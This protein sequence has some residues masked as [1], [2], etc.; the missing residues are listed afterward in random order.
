MVVFKA[1]TLDQA[2]R[3]VWMG[4]RRLGSGIPDSERSKIREQA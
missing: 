4:D 3:R 2:R 1:M